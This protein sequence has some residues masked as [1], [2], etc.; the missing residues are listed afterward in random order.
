[1]KCGRLDG[2]WVMGKLRASVD[3]PWPLDSRDECGYKS[4]S[5]TMT[6]R[7]GMLRDRHTLM[8]KAY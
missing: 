3:T 1:M 6:I 2:W 8:S 4:P 7:L 5:Y